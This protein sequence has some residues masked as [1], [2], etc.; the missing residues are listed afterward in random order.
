MTHLLLM[1]VALT[2]WLVL[3][4]AHAWVPAALMLA[5]IWRDLHQHL[6]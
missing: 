3:G 5:A 2:Y 4:S 6:R 1:L